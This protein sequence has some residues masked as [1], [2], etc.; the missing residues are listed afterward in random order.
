MS[1][2]LFAIVH[3]IVL[4]NETASASYLSC[5]KNY[6]ETASMHQ[7]FACYGVGV[8]ELYSSPE[9][10]SLKLLMTSNDVCM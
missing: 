9:A 7:V 6:Y 3:V 8:I 10:I 2:S 1:T 4:A 5:S